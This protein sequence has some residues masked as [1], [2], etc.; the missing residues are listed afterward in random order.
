MVYRILICATDP[1][2]NSI[3][4]FPYGGMYASQ[5]LAKAHALMQAQ[6]LRPFLTV[7]VVSATGT[8]KEIAAYRGT[9]PD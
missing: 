6:E 5:S 3:D 9:A 8:G 1:E 7:K 2:R 4:P